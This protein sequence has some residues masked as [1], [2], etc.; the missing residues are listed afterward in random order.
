MS[1][2]LGV[3]LRAEL[4]I[5]CADNSIPENTEFTHWLQTC[6]VEEAGQSVVVRIVETAESAALNQQYRHKSG[7]TNV[8]SFPFAAPLNVPDDHLGDLVIC[9][10][11][12][13]R[14][15]LQQNKPVLHHWAHLLIHGVL[16]LQGFDHIE[17]EE[18]QEMEFREIKML[19][20][21][22]I[23]DPYSVE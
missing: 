10:P 5:A 21:L 23:P 12:V 15:A 19:A 1:K 18:A 6:F 14:E 17:P 2:P 9:A 20:R 4:Q 13:S 16:H 8:L 11:L 22:G 3:G 7:P